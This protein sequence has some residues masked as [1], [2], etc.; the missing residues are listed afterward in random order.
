MARS[1]AKTPGRSSIRLPRGGKGGARRRR[2]LV[3]E[4]LEDRLAMDGA[5]WVHTDPE[6]DPGSIVGVA[7]IAA[8]DDYVN[9]LS[10]TGELRID[11]LSNDP[12]PTGAT[13][14]K[15]KSV[16]ATA[17]GAG[18]KVSEDRLR[19]IYTVPSGAFGN[20]SFSYIVETD[21]G[22]LG[23]ANVTLSQPVS[24][25]PYHYLPLYDSDHFT[26]YE[27]S[28][29]TTLH[30]LRND[31][32]FSVG[33]IVAVTSARIGNVR[34][35]D[36]GRA[37]VYQ[38]L[39]GQS[40]YDK[41]NYSVRLSDG[42]SAQFTVNV[43]VLKPYQIERDG[44]G[45]YSPY[46]RDI[47]TGPHTFDLLA[48]DHKGLSPETPRIVDVEMPEYAGELIISDDGQSV[49][50][51]PAAGLIGE[52]QFGYTVRYG[53]LAHQ[54]VDGSVSVRVQ[55]T[56]VSVDN[57]FLVDKNSPGVNLDVLANDPKLVR[58]DGVQRRLPD[59]GL[60]VVAWS[61][62]SRGGQV[63][64][65]A[66]GRSLRYQPAAGFQGDETFTYTVADSNGH[67]DTATVT[68]HVADPVATAGLP[69]F[70]LPGELRQFLID[71]AVERYAYS[72]G[73]TQYHYQY[74]PYPHALYALHAFDGDGIF[75]STNA[76]VAGINN[77][78][79]SETNTQVA[80]V[81]EADIVET[82][83][84]YLYTFSH[85]KLVIADLADLEHPTLV[86]F[87]T[88]TDHFTEMY[89]QGDRITL[90]DRGS[91]DDGK[92]TA[93]VMVLDVSDRAAPRIVER[94]EI[95]GQ[96]VDSRAVGNRVYVAVNGMIQLPQLEF[97]VLEGTQY[98]TYETLDE[99][100]ARLG[101]AII[102][103]SLPVYR[104]YNAAS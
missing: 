34:I 12:L 14:L 24:D 83:G 89:L 76:M 79:H 33:E 7:G 58:Y 16:S 84:R 23:K 6:P 61:A 53:P 48:N 2:R 30:V 15:I 100:V 67:R 36:D 56:F 18:V 45:Y 27:D 42:S 40:G 72:F 66:D 91:Y 92:L 64:L 49:T 65:A 46:I 50:Y 93:V 28:S 90:I 102:E 20:D 59:V 47:G 5:G 25:Y 43:N 101:D 85:G 41:F 3:V 87:T 44:G 99:Y 32:L 73:V 71:Q 26:V 95:D 98:R 19:L 29:E 1:S 52:F 55:N 39:F 35:A 80:G 60:T 81:D 17:R 37:L 88:L 77:R 97:E 4:L 31:G 13:G 68:V 9:L 21:D 54:S 51:V 22:K 74:Y 96:I 94:T 57:W 11:V 8:E 78:S 103:K 63:A 86:S 62:G 75:T 10:S 82:D 70:H 69:K 104:S 38:P